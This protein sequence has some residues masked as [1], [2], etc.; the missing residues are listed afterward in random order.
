MDLSIKN[1]K[2]DNLQFKGLKG[3]FRSNNEPVIEF[4]AP[5]YDKKN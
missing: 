5:P 1:F 3:G 2:K 4:I